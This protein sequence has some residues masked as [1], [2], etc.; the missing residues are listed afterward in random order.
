MIQNIEVHRKQVQDWSD[1]VAYVEQVL[2][3]DRLPLFKNQ[4]VFVHSRDKNE[5]WSAL[6]EKAYAK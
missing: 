2:V 3:D 1:E 4:L 5:F 6:V